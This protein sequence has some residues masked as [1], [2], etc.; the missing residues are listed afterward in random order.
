MVKIVVYIIV[1]CSL[2]SIIYYDFKEYI[3]PNIFNILLSL[4]GVILGVMKSDISQ[5]VI[6]SALLAFPF[7]IIYC[8]GYDI[9]KREPI[10][11]GDI[12]LALSLGTIIKLSNLIKVIIFL[13]KMK[14]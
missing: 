9:F 4:S 10:G 3:I 8:Y 7:I 2:L 14:S 12:K 13:K 1:F 6:S 11:I 5:R